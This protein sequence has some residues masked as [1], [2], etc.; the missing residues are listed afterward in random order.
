MACKN[1]LPS[2]TNSSDILWISGIQI[3]CDNNNGTHCIQ[4]QESEIPYIDNWIPWRDTI[5]GLNPD[6]GYMY[7]LRVE[8]RTLKNKERL[9]HKESLEYKL[10]E[11]LEKE[12]DPAVALYDI[13]GLYSMNQEILNTSGERPQLELDLSMNKVRGSAFCNQIWGRVYTLNNTIKFSKIASTRRA[14]KNLESENMY[15]NLLTSSATFK[16]EKRFLKFYNSMGKEILAFKK[17]D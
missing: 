3:D 6:F 14:C 12:R 8:M 15:I 13:W 10:I 16:R 17:L 5:V 4:I 1:T 2:Q 11:V 7:K 9:T